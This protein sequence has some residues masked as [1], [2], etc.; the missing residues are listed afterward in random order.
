M[1]KKSNMLF[2]VLA[3]FAVLAGCHKDGIPDKAE[4]KVT[5]LTV[6]P[7]QTGAVF[8]WKVEMPGK[9]QT[10]IEVSGKADMA[11]AQ[12]V[13]ATENDGKYEASVGNLLPD[14]AYYYR[15][16]VWNSFLSHK[17]GQGSFSTLAADPE[18]PDVF[19]ISLVADPAEGGTMTGG[20][21][22]LADSVCTV[23]ATANEGYCFVNWTEND[24]QVST[25]AEYTFSVTAD[26]NLVAHFSSQA[27]TITATA[28]PAAGGTVSGSGGYDHGDECRLTATATEGYRFVN[29]TKNDEQVSADSAYAFTV[30]ETATYIAHFQKKT[31]TVSVAADPEAGGTVTGGGMFEHGQS[32]TV[33][34]TANE[35]F[36]F[37]GWSI[38]GGTVTEASEY[39][40]SVTG[41]CTLTATFAEVPPGEYV[42]SVEAS[43]TDGGT[44][45]GGGTYTEGSQVTLTA[46]ANEG[47]TFTQWQDGN[48]SN[49]RTITVTG[50]ATYTATF[51]RNVY[52]ITV[53]ANPIDGGTVS[54]G[55]GYSYGDLCT[56]SATPATGYTF[57]N[58]TENGIPFIDTTDT[59]I[60]VTDNRTFVAQ[61]QKKSY[62]ISTNVNPSGSGSVTGGG[63]YT[64]GQTCT[65]TALPANGYTFSQWQDGNNENPR[66][67]TVY[68]NATY[69]A[70]FTIQHQAPTGAI[71][72]LF[73]INDNGDQVYFSQGN[74]QYQASTNTWRFATN[75]YDYI[76][77]DNSNISQTYSGWIDLFGW[78]TSGYN[79]GAVC[80]QPWSTSANSSDYYAYNNA[81][82]NLYDQTGRADWGYNAISNGGNADNTWRT[83]T[84]GYSGEWKY[85]FNRRSTPS[86]I[87]Y[88]KAQV[89]GVNGVILLPDD[90][91]A[92]YYSLNSTNTGSASFNS[93]VIS[94]SQWNT[95]E[96]HGAV[97]LPAAGNRS[98]T[99]ISNVGSGG[100]YWSASH[101]SDYG[102]NDCACGVYFYNVD[103]YNGNVYYRYY[104]RSV[105]LV[106]PAEN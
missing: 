41:D 104:G 23:T 34:A 80:Y 96:Q 77:N 11:D 70:Y 21:D 12:S 95:L 68:G 19:T 5:E 100:Y 75:Q 105:R 106:C 15:V 43:P 47:Y 40:F 54:G 13:E 33:K 90:W 8:S 4:P 44:V 16:V 94:S 52:T 35:G 74:L 18:I 86:S 9:Y 103:L 72:G 93:N 36:V 88:A 46:T 39:T 79:H 97:F 31:Y 48:T 66:T 85:I 82:Y 92:S 50:D 7:A 20:G 1:M 64:Y 37:Q 10:C 102:N 63:A 25:D 78:G 99:S 98:G 3:V 83:L 2:L 58:W 32:C 73:T 56:L 38:G 60:I 51:T 57:V 26:R 69:T 45:S 28:D 29:W 53:S 76:G 71:N 81:I 22:Y 49:P 55:G 6:V 14:T 67:I 42:I 87:R 101:G 24:E 91:S 59:T 17:D 62:T 89:A 61:F 30:T 84:G 27:Y 65:L